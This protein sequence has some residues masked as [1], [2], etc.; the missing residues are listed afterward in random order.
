MQ[1]RGEERRKT[2]QERRTEISRNTGRYPIIW[3][4][5]FIKIQALSGRPT[6][7]EGRGRLPFSGKGEKK[8]KGVVGQEDRRKTSVPKGREQAR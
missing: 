2:G 5:Y 3:L 1:N 7:T 4:E 6:I 8:K